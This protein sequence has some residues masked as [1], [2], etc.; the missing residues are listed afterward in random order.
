MPLDVREAIRFC[1]VENLW[2]LYLW[3]PTGTGKSCAAAVAYRQ[4][5]P[6]ATWMSLSELCDLLKAFGVSPIQTIQSGGQAVE[7]TLAKFWTRLRDQGLVVVDE[8]GTREATAHRYDA[9]RD[10][11]EIRKGKPLIVTGNLDPSDKLGEI[12]D[13]RIQS[14][15]SAGVL[16]EVKGGDRRIQGLAGRVRVSE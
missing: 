7:I 2:P 10:L 11:L 4:W 8:I 13:E 16:M 9:F 12:Y 3:G 1:Q 14:R 6:S 15:I 5:R